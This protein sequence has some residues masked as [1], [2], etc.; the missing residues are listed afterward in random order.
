[1]AVA[2]GR[3]MVA[4]VVEVVV[5]AAVVV[6]IV[7]APVVAMAEVMEILGQ[8]GLG[9]AR[10]ERATRE[11]GQE[12]LV[13]AVLAAGEVAAPEAKAQEVDLL[14]SAMSSQE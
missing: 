4:A 5:M 13:R 7:E 12:A 6:E 2:M 10:W 11:L 8:L 14:G 3:A 1:M 9:K